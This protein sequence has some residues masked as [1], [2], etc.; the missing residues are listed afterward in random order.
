M[1]HPGTG[2]FAAFCGCCQPRYALGV[3]V[4]FRGGMARR[5]LFCCH[6]FH[7]GNLL[8]VVL[9]SALLLLPGLGCAS[10]ARAQDDAQSVSPMPEMESTGTTWIKGV[11]SP[12]FLRHR[13]R[14]SS[15]RRARASSN[16]DNRRRQ[17]SPERGRSILLA[18]SKSL[19][20]GWC[21]AARR[22]STALRRDTSFIIAATALR[23]TRCRGCC[24]GRIRRGA[25]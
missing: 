22:F 17:L 4:H 19:T 11:R 18:G 10:A 24:W 12:R 1:F 15:L 2:V 14:R 9:R 20:Y 5:H 6:K 8:E 3:D 25:R 16:S 7:K 23:T 21:K 13:R